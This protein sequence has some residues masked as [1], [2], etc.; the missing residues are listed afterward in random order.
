M[1]PIIFIPIHTKM[2]GLR[3]RGTRRHDNRENFKKN[4]WVGIEGFEKEIK[5][6]QR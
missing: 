6:E 4:D 1:I 3:W 5:I 2:V